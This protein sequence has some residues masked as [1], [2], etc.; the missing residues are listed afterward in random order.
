MRS[1]WVLII[2]LLAVMPGCKKDAKPAATPDDV[3]PVES[4]SAAKESL[5]SGKKEVA[6][7]DTRDLLL[8]L[9]RVHFA[10]DSSILNDEAK[11]ALDEAAEKLRAHPEVALFVDGHTDARGTT[12]YNMSL[13]DQRASSVVGYLHRSGVESERLTKV[14]F[15]EESPRSA[16]SSEVVHAENRRVEYRLM[17]GDIQLVLEDTSTVVS[18][19]PTKAA[20]AKGAQ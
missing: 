14:S 15:G 12:E 17:R 4:D 20:P 1:V 2:S 18:E 8:A 5:S 3:Q 6:T 16:G 19:P 9:K 13:G 11:A 7:G 10:F